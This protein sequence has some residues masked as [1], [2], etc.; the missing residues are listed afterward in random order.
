MIYIYDKKNN[1]Y[2]HLEG[3]IKEN[4]EK[5]GFNEIISTRG[6]CFHEQTRGV[7]NIT[8]EIS[9]LSEDDYKKLKLI[10]L[11]ST[12]DLYVEDDDTGTTYSKY[13]IKGNTLALEKNEDIDTK[14]YYY[15]G[16]L[17]LNKR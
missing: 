5:R 6:I 3:T 14:E 10:F 11:N 15:K 13:F 7:V 4:L 8:I 17:P 2:L 9:F 1:L 16:S 12:S